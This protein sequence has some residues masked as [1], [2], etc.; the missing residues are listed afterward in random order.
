MVFTYNY[1]IDSVLFDVVGSA[2]DIPTIL[3][4]CNKIPC[5]L[6]LT[7]INYTDNT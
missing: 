7:T 3:G 1:L 5:F 2:Y 6:I 4:N